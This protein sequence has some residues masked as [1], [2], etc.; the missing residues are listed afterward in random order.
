MPSTSPTILIIIGITGDLAQRKLL[1]AI[2]KMAL[3]GALPDEFRIVGITRK[4]DVTVESLLSKTEHAAYITEHAELFHMDL[5]SEEDYEKLTN[6]LQT[7]GDTFSQQPQRLFYLSV[8]PQVSKPIIEHLGTSGLAKKPQTKLLLEKPFGTDLESAKDLIEHIDRYFTSEQIYRIDHYLARDTAQNLVIFREY[9]PLFKRTWNK[10]FI[11]RIEIT[12]SEAIGIEGRA[13]FYEQTGA[14]R[15]FMQ[16]HLLQLAALAL[17]DTPPKGN[18]QQVPEL[19]LTALQQLRF[20][21]G[22]NAITDFAYRGQ[23]T[24]YREEVQN[25]QSMVET[26]ASV[27][28]ESQDE[29]WTGVPIV[30]T[31]GKALKSRYT[32]IRIFYKKDAGEE[33]EELTLRLQPDEGVELCIWAKRPGYEHELTQHKVKFVFG[34]R[35][36]GLPEPYGQVLFS[37][38]KSDHAL[39]TSGEEVLESWKILDPIQRSWEMSGN[40]L[41]SY[42]PGS[43][44]DEVLAQS[45]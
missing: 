32:E 34:D 33:P 15:D 10:E 29:K 43:T 21:T 17:M 23:Y 26:F 27:R 3:A 7:L 12:A 40:D 11:E 4:S 37:A 20:P 38:I 18:M 19:R 31:T 5:T 28:L 16:S 1:P 36:L 44:P 9:N 45:I 8:P 22:A 35:E 25:P 42:S 6:Y 41:A 30:L 13:L 2:G 24:G 14:L 39:F